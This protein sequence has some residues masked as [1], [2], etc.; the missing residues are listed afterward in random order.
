M[1]G[2]WESGRAGEWESER[3]GDKERNNLVNL[4]TSSPLPPLSPSLS[5][6][7]RSASPRETRCRLLLID[8]GLPE[9]ALNHEVRD[10][11]GRV[12]A[13]VD[14]AYPEVR[15]AI[16]YEGEHH[17]LAPEQWARDLARYEALAAAG[18]FVIR[19][20]AAHLADGGAAL[21]ARVRAALS[22]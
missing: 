13:C 18:W 16:E 12:I 9:P 4:V 2:E 11:T 22:R 3:Q 19:V 20:S 6:R 5:L 21:A 10:H 1:D 14:L 17:L 8:A 7:S 15:V